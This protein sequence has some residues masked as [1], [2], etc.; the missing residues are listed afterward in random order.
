MTFIMM[1]LA[2]LLPLPIMVACFYYHIFDGVHDVVMR[3]IY[4]GVASLGPSALL[5][6][7]V[8]KRIV[9]LIIKILFVAGILYGLYHFGL[10]GQTTPAAQ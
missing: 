7:F 4:I 6:V 8:V 1:L 5:M 10:I 2:Y 3:L 9:H